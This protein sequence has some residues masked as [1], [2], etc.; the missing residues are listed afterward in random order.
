[1]VNPRRLSIQH[2]QI[3]EKTVFVNFSCVCTVFGQIMKSVKSIYFQYLLKE[4]MV[5]SGQLKYFD[6]V[7][8]VICEAGECSG[9]E[10]RMPTPSPP[11]VGGVRSQGQPLTLAEGE[12]KEKGRPFLA[13]LSCF[14]RRFLLAPWRR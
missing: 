2:I 3:F 11:A 9:G 10:I 1:M 5:W 7:L 4:A 14:L 13:A 6:T 12:V 8:L